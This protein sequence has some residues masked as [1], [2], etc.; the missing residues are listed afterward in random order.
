MNHGCWVSG[1]SSHFILCLLL[2]YNEFLL[3]YSCFIMLCQ[4]LTVRQI[5]LAIRVH[6]GGGLVAKL[7]PTLAAP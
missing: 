5:E 1:M 2:F 4:F 3:E 6:G 7:C